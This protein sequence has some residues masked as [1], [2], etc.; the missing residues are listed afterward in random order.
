MRLRLRLSIF[1]STVELSTLPASLTIGHSI[2]NLCRETLRQS[3]PEE[4]LN[5]SRYDGNGW[6]R[7]EE[8]LVAGRGYGTEVWAVR[9]ILMS[10]NYLQMTNAFDIAAIELRNPQVTSDQSL[11]NY[12]L[13][14]LRR[15]C[16]NRFGQRKFECSSR[17]LCTPKRGYVRISFVLI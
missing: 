9:W 14:N 4:L 1:K 7:C 17:G 10:T 16:R 11:P 12:V 8:R 13:R 6:P 3:R 15:W 2:C 5:S